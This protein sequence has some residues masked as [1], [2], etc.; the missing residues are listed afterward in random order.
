VK[1]PS[2]WSTFEVS[3]Y[4][5]CYGAD[6]STNSKRPIVWIPLYPC[7]STEILEKKFEK[8]IHYDSVQIALTICCGHWRSLQTLWR[9]LESNTAVT[10][11][12]LLSENLQRP[13]MLLNKLVSEYH[14]NCT[15]TITWSVV[16]IAL[17]NTLFHGAVLLESKVLETTVRILTID[18]HHHNYHHHHHH[19]HHHH[20]Y[21]HHHH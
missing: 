13:V 10:H 7:K 5:A 12:N 14:W 20:Q 9:I 16:I 2:L 4:G 11:N 21:R 3:I 15:D 18:Y 19:H 8:Y 6:T 1:V 17:Y